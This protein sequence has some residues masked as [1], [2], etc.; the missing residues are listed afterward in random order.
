MSETRLVTAEEFER[1]PDDPV[2]RY[3]LVEGRLVRMSPVSFDHGRIVVR[4]IVLLQRHLDET[5]VG[6]I[7]ADVGFKLASNPDTVRGPDIAFVRSDRLPSR[8]TP[9]FLKQSPDAVIEVLSPDDRPSEMSRKIAQYLAKGVAVVSVVDPRKETVTSHRPDGSSVT[10]RDEN[11]L[12]D[13]SDV[14][15][16]FRC[17]LREVFE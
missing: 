12:L 17:S 15:P 7:G 6:A 13:L 5:P 16:G 14:I 10:L 1:M 4:L 9:G 8:G 11:E 2:N 3:E